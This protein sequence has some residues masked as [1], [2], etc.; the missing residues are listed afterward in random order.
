MAHS[1]FISKPREEV[2][3]VFTHLQKKGIALI[4]ESFITFE[5]LDIEIN[6]AYDVVFFGSPRAVDFFTAKHSIPAEKPI[7]CVGSITAETL[8]K[9]GYSVHFNGDDYSGLEAASLAFA[10]W[11]GTKRV[12]F[13]VSNRSLKTFAKHIP[14]HQIELHTI[15]RTLILSKRIP[16][17]SIYVFTSPS[18][19]EGFL[20]T[21][22]LPV[23]SYVISWGS[24]TTKAL[25]KNGIVAD[26][27]LQA[28]S[29]DSLLRILEKK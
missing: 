18:N 16:D 21:N 5:P 14:E 19:V 4:A 15:Y 11:V 8:E 22:S 2:Q 24:S 10:K 3:E 9:K 28:S 25:T 26:K 27:T 29:I 6:V 13:P 12:L 7:A 23:N 1:L 17:C 20:K